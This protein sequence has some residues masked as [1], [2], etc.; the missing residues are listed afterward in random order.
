MPPA[1]VSK[2]GKAAAAAMQEGP[3]PV[4]ASG[5]SLQVSSKE[6]FHVGRR[7]ATGGFAHIFLGIRC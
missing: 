3:P 4:D 6:T 2:R 7:L 1:K 5:S